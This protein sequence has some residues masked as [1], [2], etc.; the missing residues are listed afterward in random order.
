MKHF[1]IFSFEFCFPRFNFR[2]FQQLV[3]SIYFIHPVFFLELPGWTGSADEF[4]EWHRNILESEA[5]SLH[6]HS[7]IDL[8]FGYKLSGQAAIRNKN[9]C[10]DLSDNQSQLKERGVLQLFTLPH[11]V[12]QYGRPAQPKPRV[13]LDLCMADAEDEL[14]DE[15]PV[16]RTAIHVPVEYNPSSEVQFI[17]SLH[18]FVT[19]CDVQK[20][21]EK[22]RVSDKKNNLKTYLLKVK[23]MQILGCLIAELF[24]PKK[25]KA[26]GEEASFNTRYRNAVDIVMKEEKSIPFAIRGFLRK[27]LLKGNDLP[28]PLNPADRYQ[29]VSDEGL[30]LP[31]AEVL[32]DPILGGYFPVVFDPVL[33]VLSTVETLSLGAECVE[34]ATARDAISEF[35]VRTSFNV[36]KVV[37]L[38]TFLLTLLW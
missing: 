26:L 12:R 23:T 3:L 25:F 9:V 19:K 30:P 17:E 34:D 32:M 6:L 20:I 18:N 29:I 15:A 1:L 22:R 33:Q 24:F 7:W 11:P 16:K 5:V 4:I 37:G 27:L 8:T 21:R 38:G 36:Y 13:D 28:F 35:Q 31:S 14:C 2:F 10:L